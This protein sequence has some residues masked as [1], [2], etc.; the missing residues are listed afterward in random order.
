LV[1]EGSG[2]GEREKE[3]SEILGLLW[4][5]D[6]GVQAEGSLKE[7][8]CCACGEIA[9]ISKIMKALQVSVPFAAYFL[10]HNCE[11]VLQRIL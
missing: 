10:Y 6:V 7:K 8:F 3:C 9:M 5:L 1:L 2:R 11:K 4:D